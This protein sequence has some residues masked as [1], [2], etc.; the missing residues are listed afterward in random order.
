MIKLN[1]PPC[2][3]PFTAKKYSNNNC[4]T[5]KCRR[6]PKK[7]FQV[8]VVCRFKLT[9]TLSCKLVFNN[10]PCILAERA[11]LIGDNIALIGTFVVCCVC[12]CVCV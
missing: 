10:I 7:I 1:T 6:Y 8:P 11:L 12:V 2:L 3:T 9:H 4:M 5:L